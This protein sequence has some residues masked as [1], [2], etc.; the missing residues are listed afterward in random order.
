MALFQH[1][2]IY[3]FILSGLLAV[4]MLAS[5]AWNP[6]IWVSDYPPDIQ[7]RFGPPDARTQRQKQIVFLPFMLALIGTLTAAVWGL[8]AAGLTPSFAVVFASTFLV[9]L[10]FNL[11]DLLVIDWLFFVTWQPHQIVLPGTAGLA[12][13]RDYRFH[14]IAFLKGFGFCLIAALITA[15]F[16]GLITGNW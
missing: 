8:P 11:F 15:G 14:F 13:Y 12:G 16:S 7:A 10:V 5:L 2:L 6:A 9:V 4:I 3:G 1:S